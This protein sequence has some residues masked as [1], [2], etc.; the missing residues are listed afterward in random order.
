MESEMKRP[1]IFLGL[2]SL[3]AWS[4]VTAQ[5]MRFSS[6]RAPQLAGFSNSVAVSGGTVFVGESSNT[7]TPGFVYVYTRNSGGEWVEIARF[8]SDDAFDGDNFGTALSAFGDRVIVSAAGQ[9]EGSG[10][11][12]VFQK[13]DSGA[14]NQIARLSASDATEGDGLGSALATHGSTLL[15]G[16]SNQNSNAGAVYVFEE[17]FSGSWSQVAKLVPEDGEKND[18]FGASLA[19]VDSSAFVGAPGKSSREGVLYLFENIDG[20]WQERT[21][22]SA[23]GLDRN[24][25]F[26]F[27][28]AAEGES[29]IVGAA[30][31][32]RNTGAAYLFSFENGEW[33]QSG[34]LSPFDGAPNT[35]FGTTV[36]FVNGNVWIGAPGANSFTGAVYSVEA[37][38]DGNWV[39]A[40]KITSRE[41]GRR[42]SF[43][44]SVDVDGDIAVVG[45]PTADGGSG[46]A[47]I[48]EKSDGTWTE[49]AQLEGAIEA[50]DSITGDQV[51]C[52]DG[53]ADRFDCN[54]VDMVAFLSTKDVGAGRGVSVNDIWGWTDP[55]TGKEWA[56]LG[57]TNGTAFIDVSDPNNPTYVGEL[58]LTEGANPSMW[59][60]IKVYKDHAFIVADGAGAHGMQVFDLTRLR[61]ISDIPYTFEADTVYDG[62]HSAHNIVINEDTGFAYAVGSSS[63]GETC[64][65]GLHMINIQDPVNPEFAGCFSDTATGRSGTGYSHDAM[66]IVYKGPDEQY[67]GKEICFGANETALSIADVSDKSNPVAISNASYPNV[68]YAHQGWIT[69]DHKYFYLDDELDELQGRASSTRTLVWDVTDLDD[70]QLVKEYQ[71]A[72]K[73]SDHNLYI[74]GNF[75]YQSNYV[76]GLRVLDISDPVNPVEVG[77]F[78]TTHF[79]E[80]EPG[81]SGAWSNYP[82][83]ESGIIIVSSMGEGLFILKR[84]DVD[85]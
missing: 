43:G 85:I 67:E 21:T 22:L 39:S 77:Y 72:S 66:C 54:S 26:G 42:T 24:S 32:Q 46:T 53:K 17:D 7:M 8:T 13:D 57:R 68:S 41:G 40:T 19:I 78:D 76:S 1:I 20:A 25:R 73:S 14:Y 18:L 62:I 75:M 31:H 63:G 15:V 55:E 37:D 23:F 2:L 64:G 12:Y 29:L 56:L 16:A 36:T 34:S 35:R 3:F 52:E 30:R 61:N 38:E 71:S 45:Q 69:E 81:F 60:D 51:S 28:V 58:T 27:S 84:R 10:A 74:R 48:F 65:G 82:F 70:P 79:G 4:S 11:V 47:L 44:T 80:N 49:V 33:N 9:N 5:T 6:D 50:M 59:R 83:F